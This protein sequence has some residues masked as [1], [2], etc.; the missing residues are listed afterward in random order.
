MEARASFRQARIPAGVALL[1]IA[2]LLVAF[3]LGSV[4]GYLV[5][6]WTAPASVTTTTVDSALPRHTEGI[7][8]STP[9]PVQVSPGPIDANGNVIPI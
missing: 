9:L 3:L 5:R 6:A 8:Y 1:F 7:P 4:G 2:G